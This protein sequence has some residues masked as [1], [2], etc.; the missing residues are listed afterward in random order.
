[1]LEFNEC[2]ISPRYVVCSYG[3]TS[4]DKILQPDEVDLSLFDQ[5]MLV[6]FTAVSPPR[7]GDSLRC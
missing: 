2:M 5:E 1:M 6:N 7:P 4:A 3:V